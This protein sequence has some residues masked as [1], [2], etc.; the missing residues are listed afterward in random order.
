[1]APNVDWISRLTTGSP[2]IIIAAAPPPQL[3]LTVAD[4][5]ITLVT[6]GKLM[7]AVAVDEASEPDR[8]VLDTVVRT[9]NIGVMAS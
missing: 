1:M 9:P 3:R 5:V 7:L 8:G 6:A 4:A 2:S